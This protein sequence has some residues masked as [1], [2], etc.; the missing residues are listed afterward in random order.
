MTTSLKIVKA[1]DKY[2]YG[3]D[4]VKCDYCQEKF[5]G[6]FI[7]GRMHNYSTWLRMCSACHEEVGVGLGTGKGQEYTLQPN[8]RWLK[9][10]G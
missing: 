2:W 9:T 3:S 6:K 8:G 10:A 1:V 4:P 5:N 7:D